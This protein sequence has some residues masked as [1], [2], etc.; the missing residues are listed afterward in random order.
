MINDG[1]MMHEDALCPDI[2]LTVEGKK[3][4]QEIDPIGNRI[5]SLLNEGQRCL[6]RPEL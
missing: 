1:H 6:P 3:L 2:F 5:P 4:N